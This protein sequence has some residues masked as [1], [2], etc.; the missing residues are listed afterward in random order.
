MRR[1]D[2]ARGASP[3]RPLSP[4][5]A[6]SVLVLLLLQFALVPAVLEQDRGLLVV[7]FH[8]VYLSSLFLFLSGVATRHWQLRLGLGLLLG[9]AAFRFLPLLAERHRDW[10]ADGLAAISIGMVLVIAIRRFFSSHE[11]TSELISSAVSLYLLAGILWTILYGLLEAL[12]PGSFALDEAHTGRLGADLHYF[13]FATMTTVGYGDIVPRSFGAKSAAMLQAVF[14]QLFLVV[15][16]GR[17]AGLQRAAG[18]RASS[19][20]GEPQ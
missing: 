19:L 6:H 20:P 12:Q 17:L 14:G 7:L 13:S 1:S 5:E 11:F 3:V 9:A 4:A 15:L 8:T 16:L 2:P 10:V 18:G